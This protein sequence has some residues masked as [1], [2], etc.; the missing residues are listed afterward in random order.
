MDY[1]VGGEGSDSDM[2]NWTRRQRGLILDENDLWIAATTIALD[3]TLVTRDSDFSGID[4]LLT[5]ALE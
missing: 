3:A 4:G 2:H 1:W 5:V